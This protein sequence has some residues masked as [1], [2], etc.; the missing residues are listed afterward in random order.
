MNQNEKDNETATEKNFK[1]LPVRVKMTISITLLLGMLVGF[2]QCVL[3]SVASKKTTS[4][5]G[6]SEVPDP[7]TT[8]TGETTTTTT[9]AKSAE[10]LASM[11][12][13][14]K[15]FDQIN[16]TMSQLTGIPTSNTNVASVY[17]DIAI[18]LPTDNNVQNFL[19]SM[20][21]AITKL[22]TEYCDRLIEIG[23]LKATIWPGIDFTQT[24][25]QTLTTAKKTLL[26]SQ[27]ISY[28]YGPVSSSESATITTEL[29]SLYDSLIS[30]ESLTTSAT[31]KKVVKGLCT[32]S[33]SSAYVTFL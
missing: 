31:T 24:P 13:G 25:T 10:A 14:I 6:S 20:Q 29:T 11:D 12:V 32:A 23:T 8:D 28:F 30:G 16:Y 1:A 15:N 22:A 33:L 5:Y 7:V 26:I 19:P 21:V 4:T 9:T 18:Q 17:S 2:N 27:T 3:N